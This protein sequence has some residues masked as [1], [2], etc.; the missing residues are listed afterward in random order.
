MEVG[1][2]L[3]KKVVAVLP[4]YNERENIVPLIV[5]VRQLG[6]EVLVV[7]DD[8][9]DG[10]ASAAEGRAAGDGGVHVVVRRGRR[11][12]GYA[13]AEGF[14]W[15]VERG[16]DLVVEMDADFSHPPEDVP[17][18]IDAA[19][20]ADVVV[21]SRLVAGGGEEGRSFA[22][23]WLTYCSNLLIRLVLGVG[24][25]DCTT[26]F[27][28]FRREALEAVRP[29]R[30]FSPGPG[31]V[32]EVLYLCH[33]KGLRVREIPFVFRQRREGESKLSLGVLARTFTDLWR[34]RR[35]YRHEVAERK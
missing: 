11:G 10:T 4:T 6:V 21:A 18:L 20:D 26:G 27:R 1:A 13:G 5:A 16:Y 33:I 31:I 3:A 15:A 17:R 34:I 25:R 8:S 24:V 9:P 12:R 22:R 32:Q 7:D 35:A 2:G 14:R 19:R 29:D 23:R 30:L 28:C